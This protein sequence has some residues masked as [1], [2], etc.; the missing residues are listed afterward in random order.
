MIREMT[1]E[2]IEF[3][4]RLVSQL[5]ADYPWHLN[6]TEDDDS[7]SPAAL[8]IFAQEDQWQT[9]VACLR[10]GDYNDRGEDFISWHR[11]MLTVSLIEYTKEEEE[12]ERA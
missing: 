9:A 12:D 7:D 10:L 3:A 6:I 2:A 1:Y 4:I 11:G 5:P 8:N